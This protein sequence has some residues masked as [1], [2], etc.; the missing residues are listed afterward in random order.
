MNSRESNQIGCGLFEH[1]WSKI[2]IRS[3]PDINYIKHVG[4]SR[5]ERWFESV[6]RRRDYGGTVIEVP[7]SSK[8]TRFNTNHGTITVVRYSPSRDSIL[9][10]RIDSL[11]RSHGSI[12][13]PRYHAK[14]TRCVTKTTVATANV[15]HSPEST[16]VRCFIIPVLPQTVNNFFLLADHSWARSPWLAN[17]H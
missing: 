17:D 4:G 14:G 8:H 12:H 6:R 10:G 7:N 3:G 9:L 1:H 11:F 5:P 2:R 16:D 13:S 15:T